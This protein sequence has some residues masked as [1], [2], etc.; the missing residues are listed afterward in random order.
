M[1]N[2]KGEDSQAEAGSGESRESQVPEVPAMS[3]TKIER[4]RPYRVTLL[5]TVKVEVDLDATTEREAT[6]KAWEWYCYEC[7]ANPIGYYNLEEESF[8]DDGEMFWQIVSNEIEDVVEVEELA[9]G[10]D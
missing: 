3:E 4:K 8:C 7:G 9:E 1:K 6:A 10:E 2:T 5:A